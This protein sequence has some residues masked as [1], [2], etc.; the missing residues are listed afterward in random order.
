MIDVYSDWWEKEMIN[1]MYEKQLNRTGIENN[2]NNNNNNK[3]AY[4]AIKK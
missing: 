1:K 3:Y 2:N 4:I